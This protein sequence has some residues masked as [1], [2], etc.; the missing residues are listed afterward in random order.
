MKT[1]VGEVFYMKE[2][3]RLLELLGEEGVTEY[4]EGSGNVE[5]YYQRRLNEPV[6]SG[7]GFITE[8]FLKGC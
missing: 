5:A 3:A 7:T 4:R 8:R 1:Q 2:R 6:S